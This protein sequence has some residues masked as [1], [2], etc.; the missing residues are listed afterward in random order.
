MHGEATRMPE[1]M[2]IC[3]AS[4]RLPNSTTS[5]THGHVLTPGRYVGAEEAE[6]DGE[7]FEDKIGRLSTARLSNRLSTESGCLLI[8]FLARLF[9]SW[10]FFG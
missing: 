10:T 6:A 9:S 8:R 4:V 3:P 1:R 2:S 5:G 7:P